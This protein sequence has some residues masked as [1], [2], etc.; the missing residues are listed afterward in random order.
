VNVEVE[1]VREIRTTYLIF[2]AKSLE[3]AE[4]EAVQ[5]SRHGLSK[6]RCRKLGTRQVDPYAAWSDPVLVRNG[7]IRRSD[8]QE[9]G[10]E[11]APSK[12]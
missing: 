3:D 9:E 7:E 12:D 2:N 1:V 6:S 10:V 11:A 5:C 8:E 4:T